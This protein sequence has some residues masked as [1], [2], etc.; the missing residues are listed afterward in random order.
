MDPVKCV[1]KVWN[2]KHIKYDVKVNRWQQSFFAF[3]NQT[4]VLKNILM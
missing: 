1:S 2:R 4:N 3:S